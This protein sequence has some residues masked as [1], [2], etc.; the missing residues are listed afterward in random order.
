MN[1]TWENVKK[2]NFRPNFSWNL[3][4]QSFSRGKNHLMQYS[5]K[6]TNQT[7]ENRENLILGPI[8]ARLAQIHP[9]PAPHFLKT[10]DSS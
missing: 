9:P 10:S 7:L 6:L 2:T 4:P 1:Q 5:G 3:G 8:L